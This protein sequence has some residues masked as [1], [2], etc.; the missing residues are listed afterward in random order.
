[1]REEDKDQELVTYRVTLGE[2][3]DYRATYSIR[4]LSRFQ[5]FKLGLI[6]LLGLA[7]AAVFLFMTFIV[8]FI[9]AIPLVLLG[10]FWYFRLVWLGRIR[11]KRDRF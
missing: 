10:L 9:L 6:G 1:M 7:M 2:E 11:T 8:G 5:I 4:P 3:E